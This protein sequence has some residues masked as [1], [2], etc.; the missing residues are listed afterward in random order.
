MRAVLFDVDGTLIRAGGAGREALARGAAAAFG[1]AVEDVRAI[2]QGIDF[3]GRVDT[4]LI[5]EF[6]LRAGRDPGALDGRVLAEYLAA[7]PD[8]LRSAPYEIL[9]GVAGLVETLER[10][11]DL[12]VGLL[13]GNVRAGARLKLTRAGLE[14]LADR[15]GGFGDDGADRFAVA[16]VGVRRAVE[17]GAHSPGRVVVV[18]DTEHDVFAA[19]AAGARTVAVLTGWTDAHAVAAAQ[20]DLLLADLSDPEPLLAFLDRV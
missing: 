3:R 8:M 17:A 4:V 15:P 16:A 18:G 20:P 13:T 14:R 2:A 6:T 7:L 1:M 19:R 11:G 5:H 10:R 12:L 9:P